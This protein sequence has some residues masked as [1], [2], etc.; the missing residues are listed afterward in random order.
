[1]NLS[2]VR[3]L[4]TVSL[5]AFTVLATALAQEQGPPQQGPPGGGGGGGGGVTTPNPGPNVPTSPF[6]GTRDRQQQPQFPDPTR[7]PFPE[8]QR[9]VFLSG[10]VTLEDGSPPPEPVVIERVCNGVHRPEGYTDSKGRFSFALGQNSAMMADASVNSSADVFG[11]G[12]FGG[13][14]RGNQGGFGGTG[15]GIS[16]RDLMGCEIRASL[17]GFI[18]EVVNLSGRRFMDN[19]DLGTIVMRKLGG[20]EGTTISITT[21]L[22]PKDAKKAYEKGQE[23]AKKQKLGDAQKEYEKAVG[24]YPKYA[25]AWHELGLVYKLQSRNEQA[26]DAF[27]KALE[28]DNKFVKPYLELA[29]LS[30]GAQKWQEVAD[31]TDRVIRLNPLQ[32][33]EAFFFNAVAK[34]NLQKFDDAEK[35][36]DEAVKLDKAH[37]YPKAQHILAVLQAMRNDLKGAAEN[38]RG[39][40][41]H[42]PQAGDAEMVKGQLAEIEKR[43]GV[44]EVVEK[45]EP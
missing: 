12:G 23:N 17:P 34:Y 40:L 29:L 31:T 8:M 36:A 22:A 10:K 16:E 18:S 19:P 30:A 3:A 45:K 15:R 41:K 43:L 1:M 9:P 33:P 4:G 13:A 14:T 7:Q 35:S 37:R 28:A 26:R 20:V 21:Q 32:F 25:V 24:L 27:A 39:Y 5:V 42:A 11:G 6:P 44:G 2:S 38:M